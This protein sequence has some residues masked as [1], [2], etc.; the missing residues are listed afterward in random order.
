MSTAGGVGW[1]G[2][3][4]TFREVAVAQFRILRSDPTFLIKL[5]ICV[6]VARQ[7][8]DQTMQ[9][10][11]KIPPVNKQVFNNCAHLASINSWT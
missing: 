1:T 5:Y 9:A 6:L 4:G 3:W 7:I 8:T 10:Y 2:D 11:K